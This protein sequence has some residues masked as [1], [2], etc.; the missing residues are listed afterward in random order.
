MPYKVPKYIAQEWIHATESVL[1]YDADD[2][3]SPEE[4]AEAQAEHAAAVRSEIS[5]ECHDSMLLPLWQCLQ[6]CEG[7]DWYDEDKRNERFE[8]DLGVHIGVY[9]PW[10]DSDN[11]TIFSRGRSRPCRP[12]FKLKG[13]S[14]VFDS[15]KATAE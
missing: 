14:Y 3:G 2:Y 12:D 7:M 4:Y 1:N 6:S 8:R 13:V 15:S 10:R 11:G 5:G 9:R